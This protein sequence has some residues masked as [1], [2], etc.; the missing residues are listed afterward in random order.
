MVFQRPVP[1]AG[2]V[3]DNLRVAQADIDETTAARVLGRV[4]LAA[5]ILDR[6]ADVL[7]GG[8]SQ[9]MCLARSLLTEPEVVLMDEPTSSLDPESRTTIEELVRSL[10]DSGTPFVWVTH[11]LAQIGRVA[12]RTVLLVDGAVADDERTRRYLAGDEPNRA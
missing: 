10:A 7:S 4:G 6:P 3:R 1:F 8:E 12:D 9:R 5:S 11:D 2:T